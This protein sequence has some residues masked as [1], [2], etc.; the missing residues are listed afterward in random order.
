MRANIIAMNCKYSL[1]GGDCRSENIFYM[2]P[3]KP[4]LQTR[5]CIGVC[6]TQ[7]RFRYAKHKMSFKCGICENET[8]LSKYIYDLKLKSIDCKITWEVVARV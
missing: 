5:F 3:V 8:E 4:E 7:F 2:V 1:K 6:S